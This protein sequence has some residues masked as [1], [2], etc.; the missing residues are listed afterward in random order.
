M[1]ARK[2]I[3]VSHHLGKRF[4]QLLVIGPS[5]KPKTKWLDL[6][7]CDCGVEKYIA[8][9]DL[10]TGNSTSCGCRA[11]AVISD[12]NT[13]HGM[14]G[15]PTY[16]SWWAMKQR[17]TY[18]NH[19]E[20]PRYGAAGVTL[21]DR[22]MEFRNFL[23]D[24]GERPAG[25]YSL[26]RIDN[27]CGYEPGNVRWATRIEQAN[28]CS[29][30]RFL[31]AFGKT[32]TVAQWSREVGIGPIVIAKRLRRGWSVERSLSEPLRLRATQ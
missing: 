9:S 8:R 2:D 26:D 3:A 23:A 24:M 5:I 27:S 6:C 31:T 18:P 22:W 11:S 10:G 29:S 16:G 1:A 21:C 13:K 30:N 20:Y 19:I 28:N 17:C 14:Y 25:L 15:T 12:R 7:R 32:M 4:G